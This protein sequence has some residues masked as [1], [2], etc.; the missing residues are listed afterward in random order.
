MSKTQSAQA[1]KRAAASLIHA[2][3]PVAWAA[4]TMQ[5][6]ADPW[7][8]EFLRSSDRQATLCNSR[9]SGKS[10]STSILAAHTAKFQ[11]GSLSLLTSPT[12]RQATELLKKVHDV[13][14]HPGINEKLTQ[15]AATSLELRNGSRVV[16]L[17]ATPE[18]IRGYSKPAL[19]VED[20][21]AF[22]ENE[23]HL[24]LRPMLAT[25]T[26]GRFLLLSTP[27]GRQGHFFEA[28]HSPSWKH[29]KVT[30]YD[31]PR[32]TKE[33]L[34]Q[35]LHEHGELYFARE[36]LCEF[37]DSEFSFFGSDMISAAFNCDAEPLNLPIF[38]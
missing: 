38:T 30:A 4:D 15:D 23:L 35:E 12:Q 1:L 31:C 36:Y 28:C 22:C 34:E 33:F 16:S 2:I 37:S 29:Y 17:P 10:T 26:N 27:A 3:D 11:P 7:Q 8:A 6:T 24:A 13:L 21:A 19:V 14:T 18:A 5:W 25:S 9:Q 32:I 20:E